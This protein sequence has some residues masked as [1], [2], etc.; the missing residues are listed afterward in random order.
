[1]SVVGVGSKF[2]LRCPCQIQGQQ[3]FQYLRV[4]QIIGPAVGVK[5]CLI[6]LLGGQLQPGGVGI[7]LGAVSVCS[8]HGSVRE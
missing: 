1:M 2:L 7:V 5:Q 4:G 6:Q 3:P 8:I